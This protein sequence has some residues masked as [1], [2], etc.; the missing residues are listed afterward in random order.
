MIKGLDCRNIVEFL[1]VPGLSGNWNTDSNSTIGANTKE[2]T[3]RMDFIGMDLFRILKKL[4]ILFFIFFKISNNSRF[5]L[6]FLLEL[7]HKEFACS[8]YSTLFN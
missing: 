2:M 7:K 4:W 3:Q 8:K 5:Q 6:K 1:C